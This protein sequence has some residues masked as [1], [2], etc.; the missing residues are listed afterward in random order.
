LRVRVASATPIFTECYNYCVKEL[1][2]RNKSIG[3]W[4]YFWFFVIYS[5]V[6]S[7]L[8][9]ATTGS[10]YTLLG[11]IVFCFIGYGVLLTICLAGVLIKVTKKIYYVNFFQNIFY[12]ML[13][14]FQAVLL[15]L[16]GG[17][18]GDS[19]C[20]S[21]YDTNFLRRLFN[22]NYHPLLYQTENLRLFLL[23]TYLIILC[24]LVL[25]PLFTKNDN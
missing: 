2:L 4:S 11:N 25:T 16:N 24:F 12:F 20:S 6:S 18:C 23:I 17:D 3:I 22:L 19:P 21:G 10:G 5:F 9:I 15:F 8:F 14:P 7:F 1:L 13:L